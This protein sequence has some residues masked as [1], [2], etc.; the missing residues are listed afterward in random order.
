[1]PV[2]FA[3]RI[4]DISVHNISDYTTMIMHNPMSLMLEKLAERS[5][6]ARIKRHKI[7]FKCAVGK[8]HHFTGNSN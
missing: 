2:V 8:C 6:L 5:V 4:F 3:G 1:M 7:L